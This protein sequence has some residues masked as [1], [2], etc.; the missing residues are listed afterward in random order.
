MHMH[1]KLIPPRLDERAMMFGA[2][3]C[4]RIS[5]DELPWRARRV[6]PLPG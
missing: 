3:G 6:S 4:A 2:S 5:F 1:D